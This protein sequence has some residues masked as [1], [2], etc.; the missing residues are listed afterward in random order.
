MCSIFSS[1]SIISLTLFPPR[2]LPPL[3]LNSCGGSAFCTALACSMGLDPEEDAWRQSPSV[4]V[5]LGPGLPARVSARR[6]R[7][8]SSPVR[9][10]RNRDVYRDI[11]GV[12][13]TVS[14]T[15]EQSRTQRN[16]SVLYTGLSPLGLRAQTERLQRHPGS[17]SFE[18]S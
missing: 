2:M 5:F 16:N 4:P 8:E 7:V 11:F 6:G 15:E 12:F 9:V 10:H 3:N 18:P 14:N 13:F 1:N 17:L